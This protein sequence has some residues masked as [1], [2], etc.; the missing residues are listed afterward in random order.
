MKDGPSC[1]D[2]SP[3]R[4]GEENSKPNDSRPPH[5][6]Q[7]LDQGRERLPNRRPSVMR[8]VHWRGPDGAETEYQIGIGFYAN[9]HPA[10]V[11]ADGP[12]VG[13]AMRL[14][15]EDGCVIISLALQ[16]G[17]PPA[18]LAHSLGRLPIDDVESRPASVIGAVVE[19]LVEEA[20]A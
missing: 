13:S 9:G 18:A 16:H 17:V 12:K 20:A 14:L 7:H 6:P 3:G 2:G 1:G 5:A 10:E 11:F 15:L 8:A 19:A 4:D